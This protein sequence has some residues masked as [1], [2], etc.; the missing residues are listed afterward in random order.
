MGSMDEI[1]KIV[2]YVGNVIL[3]VFLSIIFLP[4]FL[5]VNYLQ[6]MWSKRLSELFGY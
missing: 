6:E 4:A 5:I 1:G 3:F 2:G